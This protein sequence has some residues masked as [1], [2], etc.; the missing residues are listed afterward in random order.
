MDI[1]PLTRLLARAIVAQARRQ[2]QQNAAPVLAH[3][4][5]SAPE[6]TICKETPDAISVYR[7]G[8]TPAN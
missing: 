7:I 5:G 1:Q 3:Q 8:G 6:E 4:D 2:V